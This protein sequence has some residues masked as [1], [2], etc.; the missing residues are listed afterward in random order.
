MSFIKKINDYDIKE[1]KN[2]ININLI[3]NFIK[4]Y[5]IIEEEDNKKPVFSTTNKYSAYKSR[6]AEYKKKKNVWK[7]LNPESE[8]KK[9]E[10]K[11]RSNLNK[12]NDDVYIEVFN[13][14]KKSLLSINNISVL[15]YFVE[16]LYDKIKFDKKFQLKYLEMLNELS[17]N[18]LI[19]KNYINIKSKNKKYCWNIIGNDKVY[20][21]FNTNS[22]VI[23]SV[24]SVLNLN[25]KFLNILQREFKKRYVYIKDMEKEEDDEKKYALK[26]NYIGVFE[27]LSILYNGKKIPIELIL[28]VLKKLLEFKNINYDIE[29]LHILFTKI[30]VKD[31]KPEVLEDIKN[32]FDLVDKSELTTRIK[33][34][35][36]DISDC[37]E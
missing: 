36:Y 22:N 14:L 34:L 31:I 23:K 18:D 29:C 19:Y 37:L 13:D 5:S 21:L 25:R 7:K 27:I 17:N 1:Y 12:M 24:K 6:R 4:I 11:I 9:I 33:F 32:R 2:Q 8:V 15:K 28:S 35:S 3:E 26:R 10:L 20:G 16:L 30:N